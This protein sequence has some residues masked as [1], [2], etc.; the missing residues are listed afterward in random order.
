M[1]EGSCA[2]MLG[3]SC[4]DPWLLKI[5]GVVS[6]LIGIDYFA[7]D[8]VVLTLLSADTIAKLMNL[9]CGDIRN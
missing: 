3:E 9:D 4:L 5:A 6:E 2:A 1:V 7:C 8:A